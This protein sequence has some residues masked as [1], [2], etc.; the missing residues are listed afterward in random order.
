NHVDDQ[1]ADGT[2]AVVDVVAEILRDQGLQVV[3]LSTDVL[4]PLARGGMPG[5]FA[6]VEHHR[7]P[8]AIFA[9]IRA[10]DVIFDYTASG[11]GSQKY[12][13]DFYL[14]S[15]YYGKRI[16]GKR[17]VEATEVPGAETGAG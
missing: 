15:H 5:S 13:L 4:L 2:D 6:E 10:A 14:L 3:T 7:L 8:K 1:D 9:A 12:N 17:A 16:V 11:R